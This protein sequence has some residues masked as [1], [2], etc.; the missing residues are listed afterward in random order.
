MSLGC[1]WHLDLDGPWMCMSLGYVRHLDMYV[2]WMCT[3]L[4]YV[5]PLDVHAQRPA[6]AR[7]EAWPTPDIMN[8]AR[9]SPASSGLIP[10]QA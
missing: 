2:T 4:G 8:Q 7:P 3:S 1:A 9:P 5:C 6:Q 10:G